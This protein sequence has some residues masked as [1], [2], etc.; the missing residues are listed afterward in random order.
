L[1]PLDISQAP[2]GA[3]QGPKG[4][5]KGGSPSSD[6]PRPK[7]SVD[8]AA[9]AAT[10]DC[11]CSNAEIKSAIATCVPQDCSSSGGDASFVTKMFDGLCKG[12]S[13]A[14]GKGSAPSVGPPAA[15]KAPSAAPTSAA[16]G[17]MAGMAGM[18]HG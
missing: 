13:A 12:G 17:G 14:G 1:S 15:A 7:I 3:G 6:A 2:K 10:R 4:P 18:N 11:F 16:K 8:P 9:L 5:P